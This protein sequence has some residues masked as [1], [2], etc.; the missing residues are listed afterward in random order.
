LLLKFTKTQMESITLEIFAA[1]L[2]RHG[3]TTVHCDGLY[4]GRREVLA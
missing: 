3:F 4:I 2:S 1:A